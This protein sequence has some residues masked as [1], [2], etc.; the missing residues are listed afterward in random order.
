MDEII[1]KGFKIFAFHGVNPEEKVEGQIFLIDINAK[2]DL[3]NACISDKV[4]DTV[5][6]AKIIKTTKEVVLAEKNNLVEHVAHRI[7]VTLLTDYEM[8][9][10]VKISIKKPN[11]PITANF[12]YVGISIVRGRD[13]LE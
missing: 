2:V 13:C 7:A 12:E 10:E 9:D 1:I 5:S 8:I 3:R 4:E 11:A 6:Y